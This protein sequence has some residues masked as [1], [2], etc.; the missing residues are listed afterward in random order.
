MKLKIHRGIFRIIIVLIAVLLIA[1]LFFSFLS[2]WEASYGR[3]DAIEDE[4]PDDGRLYLDGRY[5]I[6]NKN[7]DITLL[8]GVDKY[9]SQ[10]Q[11]ESYNNSQQSDFLMLLI[12]DKKNEICTALHLNRDTMAEIPIL[13]VRGENAGTITG[14]LALAHTYG[15]G[16]IDSCRN[17]A[18]AVSNFLY[19]VRI[20]RF[21]AFTMDAVAKINDLV[22]GVTV[23][24][25]DDMTT[26]S[27]EMKKG[28]SVTLKGDMALSFVRARSS[29]EDSSNLRRMERQRQY[30]AELRKNLSAKMQSSDAFLMD[31]LETVSP[32]MTSDCTVDQLSQLYDRWDLYADGGIMTIDGEAKL[33]SEFM[34]FYPDE[35][36]LKQQMIELFYVPLD[37]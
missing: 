17:T 24:I 10:T 35:A 11:E 16:G 30:L 37:E 21:V 36:A 13:G 2:K 31:V 6:P 34:E 20:D 29:L 1:F 23:T 19:G 14:Q 12:M 33:G 15:S 4:V 26:V 3:I 9:T 18:K 25:L 22:G 5:Y 27:S 8:I 7:L 28:A 32:Y